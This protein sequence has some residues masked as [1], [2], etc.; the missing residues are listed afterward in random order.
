MDDSIDTLVG[1]T[2]P[3][4][5]DA[6]TG[7]RPQYRYLQRCLRCPPIA[8]TLV[9]LFG[10]VL[11]ARSFVELVHVNLGFSSQGV[12]T[13]HMAVTRAKH[14]KDDRVADYYSAWWIA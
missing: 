11:F 8:I 4:P 5:W 1:D 12:L 6:R 14:R 13:M 10:G 2:I 9:L 7:N 3:T